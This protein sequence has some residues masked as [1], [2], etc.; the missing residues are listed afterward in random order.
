MCMRGQV[1]RWWEKQELKA[2]RREAQRQERSAARQHASAPAAP[3]APCAAKHS[4]HCIVGPGR[5]F[6]HTYEEYLPAQPAS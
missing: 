6:I 5:T 4:I 2:E 3:A 1:E